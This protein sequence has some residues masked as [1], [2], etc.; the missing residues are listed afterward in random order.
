ML[1]PGASSGR[2][3]AKERFW[4]DKV[5]L[6]CPYGFAIH[7]W[8]EKSKF[9]VVLRASGAAPGNSFITF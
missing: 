1:T 8:V 3:E 9:G 2:V 4:G 5:I 7:E 6:T